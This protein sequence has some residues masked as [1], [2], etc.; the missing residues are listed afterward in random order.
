MKVARL[1]WLKPMK[2]STQ[3]KKTES[4]LTNQGFNWSNQKPR[5]EVEKLK[6]I[7]T[8]EFQWEVKLQAI[9]NLKVI[10]GIIK[11]IGSVRLHWKL[12][13]PKSKE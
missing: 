6:F 13:D 10:K 11:Q 2:L 1:Q 7:T 9:K 3:L 8:T 4:L 5:I 12:T